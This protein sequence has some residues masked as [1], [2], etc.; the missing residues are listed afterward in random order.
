MFKWY[1]RW[2]EKSA[3]RNKH[4][5]QAVDN[6]PLARYMYFLCIMNVLQVIFLVA[7]LNSFQDFAA[8]ILKF[9][10]IF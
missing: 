1:K 6:R 5:W 9:A 8:Y 10:R 3:E 4:R 7:L 2:K